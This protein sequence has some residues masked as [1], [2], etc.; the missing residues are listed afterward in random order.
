LVLFGLGGIF[1]EIFEDV[2]AILSPCGKE[3]INRQLTQL[4]GYRLLKGYRGKPGISIDLFVEYILRVSALLDA[5]PEIQELD[6]NPLFAQGESIR[7]VD[8]RIRK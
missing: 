4:K 8:V 3:E 6:I 5:A 7:V 2:R 1:V